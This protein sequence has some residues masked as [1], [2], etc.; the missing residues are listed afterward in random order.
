MKKTLKKLSDK[1]KRKPAEPAKPKLTKASSSSNVG[2]M[3]KK[4][5]DLGFVVDHDRVQGSHY[6]I[7]VQKPSDTESKMWGDRIKEN[8]TKKECEEFVKAAKANLK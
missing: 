8:A 6:V 1:M 4:L 2:K 5:R 7:S 3:L